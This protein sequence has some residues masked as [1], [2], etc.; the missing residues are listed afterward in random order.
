M[1]T[2]TTPSTSSKVLESFRWRWNVARRRLERLLGFKEVQWARVVMNREVKKFIESLDYKVMECLEIGGR[3]WEGFGFLSYRSVD[4]PEYDV[5]SGT[6][7]GQTF[8]IIIA[9]QVFEHVLWP[10]RG[11]R[12]VWQMLKPGGVFVISTPF[13][14]KI[15]GA[16]QDCSRWTE[17][18]L[19]HLLAEGGF[20]L[21]NI[22]TGSWGNRAC[23]RSNFR[24]WV[25]YNPWLHSLHNESEFPV[26]V[27]GFARKSSH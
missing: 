4:Y 26:V 3:N 14:L 21:E 12:N 6:V 11:V 7:V 5:C 27:W 16:P 18:G 19:K 1:T 10:Y 8:D 15:H 9:E 20:P 17:L 23:V 25:K 13:L 24:S 2:S 22:T